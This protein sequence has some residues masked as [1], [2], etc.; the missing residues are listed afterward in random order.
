MP[1]AN[2]AYWRD[3]CGE[4]KV[5]GADARRERATRIPSDATRLAAHAL[6]AGAASGFAGI[7]STSGGSRYWHRLFNRSTGSGLKGGYFKWREFKNWFGNGPP[8]GRAVSGFRA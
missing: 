6:Q 1:A 4:A 3:A 8:L 7:E 5:L 2:A